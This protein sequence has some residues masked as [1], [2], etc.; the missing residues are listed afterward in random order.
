LSKKSAILFRVRQLVFD[1]K[2]DIARILTSEHGKVFTDAQGEVARGLEVIEYCCGIPELL[3]GGFS[4]QASTG[5]DV[6][7]IR[8]PLG[9]VAGI[10]SFNFQVMVP[11][12]LWAP[13]IIS[14]IPFV[15]CPSNKHQS[16][17]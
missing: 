7:S 1:H 16:A 9:V 3:K 10:T 11:L 14:A 8:Q 15:Q 17:S 5:I 12:W 13:A 2:D 6:Y 4:E